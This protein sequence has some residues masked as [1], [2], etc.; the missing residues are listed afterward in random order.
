MATF[1][2]QTSYLEK[3]IEQIE[4]RFDDIEFLKGQSIAYDAKMNQVKEEL[5]KIKQEIKE[6]SN[7]YD[8]ESEKIDNF[9]K[10]PEKG[11]YSK[12][13]SIETNLDTRA[14]DFDSKISIIDTKTKALELK[15]DTRLDTMSPS[16]YQIQE[17]LKNLKL[18]AGDRLE[19]LE[20]SIGQAQR[21]NVWFERVLSGA[22]A[23]GFSIIVALLKDC[24]PQ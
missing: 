12:I 24:N 8:K 2:Q 1:E 9:F 3:R 13:K 11:L 15:F 19:K 14:K 23:A 10:D 18:I 20:S 22:L 7:D 16:M 17:T 21:Q 4:K 6:L 5:V